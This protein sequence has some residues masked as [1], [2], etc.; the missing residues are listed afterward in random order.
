MGEEKIKLLMELFKAEDLD[1]LKARC[2][3]NIENWF[4]NQMDD[5]EFIEMV[6]MM[7]RIDDEA[8]YDIIVDRELDKLNLWEEVDNGEE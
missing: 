5:E 3:V 6:K 7:D 1:E 4:Y 8:I 2:P